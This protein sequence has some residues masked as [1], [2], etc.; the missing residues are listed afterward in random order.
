MVKIK[1][2]EEWKIKK[3]RKFNLDFADINVIMKTRLTSK[4]IAKNPITISANA[5]LHI[6]QFVTFCIDFDDATIH[7][8]MKLPTTA[9]TD[10]EPYK[11]DKRTIILVGT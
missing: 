3:K 11:T 8:T 5:K 1:D 6:K 10:I 2:K 4:G 9:I 7:T